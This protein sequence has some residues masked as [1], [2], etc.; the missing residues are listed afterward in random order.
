MKGRNVLIHI[1][2]H[3]SL[4]RES[5][6]ESYRESAIFRFPPSNSWLTN[7]LTSQQ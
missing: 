1:K 6:S 3:A 5:E 7:M 4:A 2:K